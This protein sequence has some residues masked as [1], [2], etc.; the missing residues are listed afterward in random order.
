MR[1]K[2]LK[3]KDHIGTLL[4]ALGIGS[5]GI[6]ALGYSLDDVKNKKERLIEIAEQKEKQQY[7]LEIP[8]KK[9]K[10]ELEKIILKENTPKKAFERIKKDIQFTHYKEGDEVLKAYPGKELLHRWYSLQELYSVGAGVCIDGAIGFCALL[11]DNPEYECKLL[12]LNYKK[13][14]KNKEKTKETLDKFCDSLNHYF[15]KECKDQVLLLLQKDKGHAIAFLKDKGKYS[16]ASFNDGSK[17]D[18]AVFEETKYNDFRRFIINKF[19]DYETFG[20]IEMDSKIMRFGKAIKSYV[21]QEKI[22]WQDISK[23]KSERSA[24]FQLELEK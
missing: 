5:F 4:I 10:Q 12:V 15:N 11:S 7:F 17:G 24:G 16:Y 20:I 21:Q 2:N 8:I 22:E 23:M 18:N 19:Q 3:L 6:L 13:I 1:I 14:P 9:T